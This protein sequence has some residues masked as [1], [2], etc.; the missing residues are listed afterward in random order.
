[1]E[2]ERWDSTSAL[3]GNH[4][5]A[6][7]DHWTFNFR[8]DPKRLGFVLA[9]YKFAAKMACKNARVLELGCSEGI[10]APILAEQAKSYTGVDLDA[11]AIQTAKQNLLY[12]FIYDD[13]MG[14]KYGEFEAVISLD[15]I[16]HI[17]GEFE[18]TYFET[19]LTNLSEEGICVIGTPNIT[20]S[21]YA[22][23]AS[24]LGHVNLYSQERLLAVLKTHFHQV[25][26]FGMNDEIVHTG[27]A[28][29]SHYLICVACHKRKLC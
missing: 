7:G 5:V 25:F 3:L 20:A 10:G 15:V 11:S 22:S 29:M 21:P 14:K 9:R 17:H 18:N 28:S 2:K 27:F 23:E 13:F 6:F 12:S 24:N 4:Q 1:M 26:P 19:I 8:N 16:E